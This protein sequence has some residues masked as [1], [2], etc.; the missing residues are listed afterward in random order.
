MLFLHSDS[1]ISS[2]HCLL[3]VKTVEKNGVAAGGFTLKFDDSH[4]ILKFA[5]WVNKIRFRVT[6]NFYGDHGIFVSRQN[7][8]RAGGIPQQALFEDIVFSHRLKKLGRLVMLPAQIVTSSRRFRKG[9]IIRTY[10][11]MA[12]LHIL[13]W[14]KV[15]PEKLAK[16]YQTKQS[17]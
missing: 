15:S 3:A 2:E 17:L 10:L 7:Y 12:M 9:G 5:E 14:F 13:Y 11:K 16:I 6:Q 8:E 1:R 4:P